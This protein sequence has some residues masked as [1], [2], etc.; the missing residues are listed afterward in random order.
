MNRRDVTDELQALRS[1]M[2]AHERRLAAW[3]GQAGGA[4]RASARNHAHY[5]ALRAADLR[6]LQERLAR[7]GLSSL[8][9]GESHVLANLDKVLGLLHVL[10]GRPWEA[11]AGDEP[12]GSVPGLHEPL[13]AQRLQ[14]AAHGGPGHAVA[15]AQLGLGLQRPVNADVAQGDPLAQVMGDR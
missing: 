10:T 9:R 2:L 6:E 8:G 12:A 11:Q 7:L 1:E 5:L 13:V 4:R 15:G 3:I 14:R